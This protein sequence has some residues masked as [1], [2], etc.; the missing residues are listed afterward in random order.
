M[1]VICTLDPYLNCWEPTVLKPEP[2]SLTR[3]STSWLVQVLPEA[4]GRRSEGDDLG[5]GHRDHRP[6]DAVEVGGARAAA[7]QHLQGSHEAGARDDDARAA[8]IAA[9]GRID[10]ED[11]RRTAGAAAQGVGE[12]RGRS[13]RSSR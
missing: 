7:E 5:G 2:G 4:A 8:F 12:A 11:R 10:R 13:S 3:T 6:L 9:R 1:A